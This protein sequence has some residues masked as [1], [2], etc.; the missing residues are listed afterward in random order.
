MTN[1]KRLLV[2]TAVFLGACALGVQIWMIAMEVTPQAERAATGFMSDP[3]GMALS[4]GFGVWVVFE[5]LY[6]R[7][8]IRARMQHCSQNE[9]RTAKL[10]R[11][12]D[13]KYLAELEPFLSSKKNYR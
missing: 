12:L 6:P 8:S 2:S 3:W 11:A 1:F 13:R 5:A 9:K 10:V 7:S 4:V